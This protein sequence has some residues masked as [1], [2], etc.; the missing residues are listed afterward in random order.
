[1]CSRALAGFANSALSLMRSSTPA[2]TATAVATG[3]AA[4]ACHSRVSARNFSSKAGAPSPRAV[5]VMSAWRSLLQRPAAVLLG[6]AAVSAGVW[7][8]Q[9]RAVRPAV[10]DCALVEWKAAGWMRC[11]Q[12]PLQHCCAALASIDRLL[13]ARQ[14]PSRP[15]SPARSPSGGGSSTGRCRRPAARQTPRHR[16]AAQAAARQRRRARTSGACLGHL[17]LGRLLTPCRCRRHPPAR[18][19]RMFLR[20][21]PPPFIRPPCQPSSHLCAAA[22]WPPTCLGWCWRRGRA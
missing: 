5:H 13:N 3:L 7:A 1:M 4:A 15:P 14:L 12:A 11:E 21:Q 20:T 9:V 8:T 16:H 22:G 6:T 10:C 18:Q 19:L 2:A 17:V